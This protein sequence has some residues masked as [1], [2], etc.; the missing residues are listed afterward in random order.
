MQGEKADPARS[1]NGILVGMIALFGNV[2]GDIVD[3]DHPVG[4]NQ[5]DKN[6][7][8][9]GKVA[10]KVHDEEMMAG[11]WSKSQKGKGKC[12]RLSGRIPGL[13]PFGATG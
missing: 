13:A 11:R 7:Q 9:E 3:G 6:N 5:N 10:E 12:Q 1:V 4:Q 8:A 2:V